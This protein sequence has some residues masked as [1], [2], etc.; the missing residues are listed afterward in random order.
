MENDEVMKPESQ[1][2]ILQHEI[3]LG[4]VQGQEPGSSPPELM[5]VKDEINIQQITSDSPHHTP[6]LHDVQDE[7]FFLLQ[8]FQHGKN[9]NYKI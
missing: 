2:G 1:F 9:L 5:A 3:N 7:E 6:P 8:S 4:V